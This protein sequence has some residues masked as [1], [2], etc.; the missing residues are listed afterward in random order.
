MS[1]TVAGGMDG[2]GGLD[3]SLLKVRNVQR[4]RQRMLMQ[5]LVMR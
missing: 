3:P 5:F 4:A 1:V 2:S